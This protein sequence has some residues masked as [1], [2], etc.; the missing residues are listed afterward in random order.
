[1]IDHDPTL[2]QLEHRP[3]LTDSGLETTLIY[4][5]GIELPDF[6]A[7][8]LLESTRAAGACATTSPPR[9]PRPRGG[10]R[11]IVESPTW[12]ANR[13]WGPQSG[14]RRRRLTDERRGDHVARRPARPRGPRPGGT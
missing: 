3:F 10:L 7:F 14:L 11:F 6:A 2:P 5:E 9:V 13:D 8:V 1:M 4:I 12:R